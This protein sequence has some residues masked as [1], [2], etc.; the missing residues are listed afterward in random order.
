MNMIEELRDTVVARATLFGFEYQGKDGN[1]DPIW[2]PETGNTFYL[3]FDSEGVTV[4]S[5]EAALDTPFVNGR[6]FREIADE[7]TITEQ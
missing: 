3:F 5:F 1:V 4:N 2:T 7:I 6:T